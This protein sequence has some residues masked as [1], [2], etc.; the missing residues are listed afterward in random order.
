MVDLKRYRATSEK[1]NFI[2]PI[3]ASIFLE[4]VLAIRDGVRVPIQFRW[5][6]QCQ[7]LK[8]W[9]FLKNRPI[10]FHISTSVIRLDKRNQLSFSNITS[11]FLPQ[12][13]VS[14]RSDSSSEANS[15]CCHRSDVWSHLEL[16][17]VS[18]ASIAV[19]QITSSG[20]SLIYSRKSVGPRMEPW[21]TPALTG[22]SCQNF[23]SRTTRSC[24]L[25]RKEEVRPNIWPE[26]L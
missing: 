10:N 19:L 2:E 3:K 25:L 5:K 18:S 14:C 12:F 15:S 8:R 4:A 11:H 17:A 16:R 6:S 23:P 9:F 24:L 21:G 13:T 22:Y 26:I 7:H 1:R 20:R